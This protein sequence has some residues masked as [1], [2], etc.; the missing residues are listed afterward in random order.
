MEAALEHNMRD[1]CAPQ[2][3]L[4]RPGV[5]V[6]GDTDLDRLLESPYPL[7]GRAPDQHQVRRRPGHRLRCRRPHPCSLCFCELGAHELP[8]VTEHHVYIRHMI[9]L[10]YLK[11]ELLG[12]EAVIGVEERESISRRFL[13]RAVA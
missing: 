2:R 1:H 13:E 3:L 11:V 10:R 9:E 6:D 12:R 4:Q 8:D 7:E 5:P